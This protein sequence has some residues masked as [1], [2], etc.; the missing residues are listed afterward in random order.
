MKSLILIILLLFSTSAFADT[1]KSIDRVYPI[2]NGIVLEES[3]VI[4][5]FV[6]YKVTE[7][8]TSTEYS[9]IFQF[10]T[11]KNGVNHRFIQV[12][13]LTIFNNDKYK[14]I[15]DPHFMI[16]TYQNIQWD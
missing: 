13:Y 6:I 15:F 5:K 4:E 8:Q 10:K 14:L 1:P 7:G 12:V 3:G 2:I 9:I 16:Q 11:K